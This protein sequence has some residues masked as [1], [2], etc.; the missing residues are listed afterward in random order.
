MVKKNLK[1][2]EKNVEVKSFGV[3]MM[4][5]LFL[6]KATKHGTF[7]GP[8]NLEPFFSCQAKMFPH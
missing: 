3:K 1:I 8:P 5:L 6:P 4:F 7:Q 2:N